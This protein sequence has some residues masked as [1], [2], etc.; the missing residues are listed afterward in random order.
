MMVPGTSKQETNTEMQSAGSCFNCSEDITFQQRSVKHLAYTVMP[1]CFI[2]FH[3]TCFSNH[4]QA[5]ACTFCQNP[6]PRIL[7]GQITG[8]ALKNAAIL[9]NYSAARLCLN[10]GLD[11]HER[12]DDLNTGYKTAIA[13]QDI[14][15]AKAWLKTG[16]H[17][18][19][20][21]RWDGIQLAADKNRPTLAKILSATS[22]SALPEHIVDDVNAAFATALANKNLALC[23]R[24]LKIAKYK[25]PLPLMLEWVQLLATEQPEGY[26]KHLRLFYD[27]DSIIPEHILNIGFTTALKKTDIDGIADWLVMGAKPDEETLALALAAVK[28]HIDRCKTNLERANPADPMASVSHSDW[29][30]KLCT[31]TKLVDYIYLATAENTLD[32][33]PYLLTKGILPGIDILRDILEKAV[34]QNKLSATKACLNTHLFDTD[35][36]QQKEQLDRLLNVALG[37]ALKEKNMKTAL[38]WLD[39]TKKPTSENLQTGL[40]FAVTTRSLSANRWIP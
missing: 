13:K 31:G 8:L 4:I 28:D 29:E 23:N 21:D 26:M 34:S 40:N 11:P 7:P 39:I 16:S 3:N 1:C 37:T 24:W 15:S 35:T 36:V 17:P 25:P 38:A 32:Q 6:V 20:Q 9:N 10:A 22:G 12:K 14:A 27:R 18:E 5:R 19:D 33:I 2:P 30:E